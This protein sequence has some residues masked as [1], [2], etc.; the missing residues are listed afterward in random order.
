MFVM[1][2][3]STHPGH[4]RQTNNVGESTHSEDK[5]FLVAPGDQ[6]NKLCCVLLET[7]SLPQVFGE[8]INHGGDEALH[9]TELGV[10][11]QEEEHEEEAAGP[12]G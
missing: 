7:F 1:L 3:L 5:Q 12:E 8:L 6:R 10:K 9:S 4:T 11:T 2:E